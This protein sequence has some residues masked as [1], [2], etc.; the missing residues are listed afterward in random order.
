MGFNEYIRTQTVLHS[1]KDNAKNLIF[2]NFH[3][4]GEG[5]RGYQYMPVWHNT[6]DIRTDI[7]RECRNIQGITGCVREG[8]KE[9]ERVTRK[10]FVD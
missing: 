7:S 4:L 6:K 9:I 3:Y 5:G 8:D 2:C 1:P 10:R